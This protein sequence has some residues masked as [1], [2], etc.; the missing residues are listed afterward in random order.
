MR[1]GFNQGTSL[2]TG[3]PTLGS[4]MASADDFLAL[5]ADF[6]EVLVL[7]ESKESR[8]ECI[9][10]HLSKIDGNNRS[11]CIPKFDEGNVW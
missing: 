10:Q 4:G 8:K 9:Q 2:L 11:S 7:K 5:L 6:D 1:V 3:S